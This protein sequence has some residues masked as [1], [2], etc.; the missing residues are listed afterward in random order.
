MKF[1]DYIT[2]YLEARQEP[3]DS[4][5]KKTKVAGF[6]I[7][8]SNSFTALVQEPELY[9]IIPFGTKPINRSINI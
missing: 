9:E 6:L 5:N 8:F 3:D 2:K 7:L 4:E 1:Q